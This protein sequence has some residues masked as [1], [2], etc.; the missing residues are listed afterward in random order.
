MAAGKYNITIEQG[1]TFTLQF[2]IKTGSTP[3]DLTGY[4]ARMQ[5][6]TSVNASATLVSLTSGSGITLGGV[7][8][9]VTVTIPATDTDN[10]IAGRHVYDLELESAGGEVWRVLEGKCTVKPEVTR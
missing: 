3:W 5:V 4:S 1:A 6:R 7:A 2:T 9:T 10:I 8:G